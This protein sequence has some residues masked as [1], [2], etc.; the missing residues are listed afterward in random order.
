ML[1]VIQHYSYRAA[2]KAT[3]AIYGQAPDYTREGGSIPVTLDFA[4]ILGLNILLLPVGR[5]DDGAHST[6]EKLDLDNYIRV[7]W[8]QNLLYFR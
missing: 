5:G 1:I 3:E 7:S 6:N 4:D 8:K 2:H